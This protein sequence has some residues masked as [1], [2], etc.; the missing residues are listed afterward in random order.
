MLN[1][2]RSKADLIAKLGQLIEYYIR[3]IFMGKISRK[4]ASETSSR[5]LFTFGKCS[6]FPVCQTCS[7]V[8]LVTDHLDNFWCFNSKRFLTFLKKLPLIMQAILWCHNYSIF[9]FP[10]DVNP[11]HKQEENYKNLNILITKKAL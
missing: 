8:Y 2:L 4:Y 7:E 1:I 5:L 10:S 6:P 9:N 11:L 3:R